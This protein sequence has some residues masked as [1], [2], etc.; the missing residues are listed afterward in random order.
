MRKTRFSQGERD[1]QRPHRNLVK[2]GDACLYAS[3]SSELHR[4][5]ERRY[6]CKCHPQSTILCVGRRHFEE[7]LCFRGSI[8]YAVGL[9]R[10]GIQSTHLPPRLFAGDS[11]A[12]LLVAVGEPLAK[13]WPFCNRGKWRQIMRQR[14]STM[15]GDSLHVPHLSVK[16]PYIECNAARSG[17]ERS[18]GAQCTTNGLATLLEAIGCG[19]LT[20]SQPNWW[21]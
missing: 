16:R 12:I 6:L 10:A 15:A 2:W 4:P 13:A 1:C 5:S 19:R 3:D 11:E 20:L 17:A 8:P 9:L 21:C 7:P 14:R 18:V